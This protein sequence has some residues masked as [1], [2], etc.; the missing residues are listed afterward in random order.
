VE[1]FAVL[2]YD[3]DAEAKILHWVRCIIEEASGVIDAFDDYDSTSAN[4]AELNSA[5]LTI[6]S[7]FF[8]RNTLHTVI[9]I[10]GDG[11]AAYN[12]LQNA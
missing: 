6:W 10:L 5:I 4:I 2:T 12:D 7:H 11:L 1:L 3:S 8:R 9:N